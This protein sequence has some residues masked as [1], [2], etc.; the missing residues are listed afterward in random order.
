MYS[1]RRQPAHQ[2]DRKVS[3]DH[4][5]VWI[6]EMGVCWCLWLLKALR[7]IIAM[8]L[9]NEKSN[10]ELKVAHL[11]DSSL[12]WATLYWN[13]CYGQIILCHLLSVYFFFFLHFAVLMGYPPREIDS[14]NPNCTLHSLRI[15][16]GDSLIMEELPPD[17]IRT[18]GGH[19]I[20]VKGNTE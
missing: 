12:T 16:S 7:L 1:K 2:V 11:P 14:Y 3:A 13:K 15:C 4:H 8:Y 17:K 18:E 6:M 5:S 9:Y 10:D 19:C 20:K